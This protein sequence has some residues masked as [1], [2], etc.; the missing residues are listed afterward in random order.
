[1]AEVQVPWGTSHLTVPLPEHWTLAQVAQPQMPRAPVDW[2]ER[3]ARALAR[4]EGTPPLADLVRPLARRGR[5]VLVL[6]DITRHSPLSELLNV[7][8]PELTHAGIAD[9]QVS[10][11]FATGMHPPMDEHQVRQKIGA[12]TDRFAWRNHD[13]ADAADHVS[14][15]EVPAPRGRGGVT[16]RVDKRLAE[17]DL[18]IVLSSVTPHL[19]AG[20]GGGGK[21]FVPGCAALETI[22]Q[23]HALG[24][25]RK[26][27]RPLVGTAAE[28]NLMRQM[29]DAAG[30]LVEVAGGATFA[31]QYV[32]DE[33]D[34]PSSLVAGDLRAGQHMLAK[35]CAAACGVVMD[36][37][38]D[39]VI[40]NA[41]PRDHDLWQSFKC[42][43][44]TAAA[45][46][47][48][49]VIVMLARCPA[50]ANMGQVRWPLSPRWTRRLIRLLGP[51]GLVSLIQ[52]FLP[53][54][55]PEAQFFL[56]L[57][58]E[59]IHRNPV[60]MY[61]P[62]LVQRGQ[63]FPGLAIYDDIHAILAAADALLGAGSRRVAVFPT[64]GT[65]YPIVG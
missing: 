61:A 12:L 44:N 56:R 29:V 8:L 39:V 48:N 34:W 63:T 4:P 1:M 18:R 15:G 11:L 17:A 42:V 16:I 65:T 13:A 25:P 3:L 62:E 5:I 47:P 23:I 50:G 19:Q 33:A 28:T 57:A 43:P 58:T 36:S 49:G 32:L 2:P 20:F 35:Q 24:L 59:T 10:I 14:V 27:G 6:E 38:A 7:I 37:P 26:A 21:M 31:V 46:R 30:Q 64:G 52:R 54:V 55:N 22:G 53:G 51:S 60:L 40:A 45:A 41:Y 9:E